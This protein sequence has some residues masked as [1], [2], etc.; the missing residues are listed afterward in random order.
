MINLRK[1]VCVAIISLEVTSSDQIGRHMSHVSE[2]FIKK[3]VLLQ[4]LL[5][6]PSSPKFIFVIK[7]SSLV[8]ISNMGLCVDVDVHV[9][10]SIMNIHVNLITCTHF[11]FDCKITSTLVKTYWHRIKI[12]FCAVINF[13]CFWARLVFLSLLFYKCCLFVSKTLWDNLE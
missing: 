4:I 1:S 9:Y 12:W 10:Y 13:Y 11:I 8:N 3:M 2:K 5:D 7:T 6:P